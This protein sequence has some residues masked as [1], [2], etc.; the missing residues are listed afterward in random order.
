MIY[1][2]AFPALARLATTAFSFQEFAGKNV[3]V[4]GKSKESNNGSGWMVNKVS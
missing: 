4:S 1:E 2:L 3:K